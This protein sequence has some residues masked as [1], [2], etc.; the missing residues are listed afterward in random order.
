MD[1]KD[2]VKAGG[3]S[4]GM[5]ILIIVA[6]MIIGGSARKGNAPVSP[7]TNQQTVT[8]TNEQLPFTRLLTTPN[9]GKVAVRVADTDHTRQLGLS[10]FSSLPS[11]QGMLF[12][13]QN[14]GMYPF[15][16]K[17]MRFSIDIIW[18]TTIAP[19]QYRV[20]SVAENISPATYPSTINQGTLP[21]DAVLEIP[22]GQS[23]NLGIQAGSIITY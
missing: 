20:N 1:A 3:L 15:W 6:I 14:P 9:G 23:R 13:F 4:A 22:A 12:V 10:G 19:G 18:M 16:M 7:D 11:N 21:A 5:V 2:T 8:E 17:N